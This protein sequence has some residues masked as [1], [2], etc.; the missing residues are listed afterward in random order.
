[1]R[2]LY[3]EDDFEYARLIQTF[4]A[5]SDL[6]PE[7]DLAR[8]VNEGVT[9][10]NAA[11]EADTNYYDVV[12]LDLLLPDSD[13]PTETFERVFD[14][15]ENVPIIV[16]TSMHDEF[17]IKRLVALGAH[18][19]LIKPQTN[20]ALLTRTIEFVIENH[21]I[22]Q[23]MATLQAEDLQARQ[24]LEE[25]TK[26]L[27]TT[28][29]QMSMR[30]QML[31]LTV[32]LQRHLLSS[33]NTA[34][35][36]HTYMQFVERL[37]QVSGAGRAYIF[38]VVSQPDDEIALQLAAEWNAQNVAPTA[39]NPS[40]AEM[41]YGDFVPFWTEAILNAGDILHE[42][43]SSWDE[44]L[45][46][47]HESR[48]TESVLL[49]PI[50]VKGSLAGIVGLDRT[51]SGND[52]NTTSIELLSGVTSELA[53]WLERRQADSATH[54]VN[55]ELRK[56]NE[57]LNAYAYTVAHDLKNPL[58][59]L[60]STISLLTES[61]IVL[62]PEEEED[63]MQQIGM[64]AERA[65]NIV[66][67]LLLLANS[68]RNEVSVKPINMADVVNS[69]L[70]NVK[71]LINERHA[72]ITQPDTWPLALGYAPWL[73]VVWVNYLS[74]AIKYGGTPPLINIG[75]SRLD[76]GSVEF[77]IS[78]NG[79]GLSLEQQQQLFMPFKAIGNIPAGGHGLGL[80]I[81]KRVLDKLG[82]TVS[83][84]SE[85]EMGKGSRFSFTLPSLVG[86][87]TDQAI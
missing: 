26:E 7:L 42:K 14:A 83:V 61:N 85:G 36:S 65:T 51:V 82:G 21:H 15:L 2:I 11:Q 41:S 38:D 48:G 39:T 34:D 63:L 74:N 45:R 29:A 20:R 30:E 78:D 64:Y 16:M 60:V 87:T 23:S 25:R 54:A 18:S 62:S 49:L 5:G 71:H 12:L 67:E 59:I 37:G 55:L 43:V 22:Y 4:L 17:L 13:N 47:L 24:R 27:I 3:I 69:A 73:E 72:L 19:Y 1:M 79:R 44:P 6:K 53:L 9:K 75:A 32:E 8:T 70:V 77:W 86:V 80:S 84:S 50:L 58:S 66:D 46:Q 57:E 28:T 76:D 52:L 31:A 68:T 10:A 40:D 81:V 35:V 33:T 56:R